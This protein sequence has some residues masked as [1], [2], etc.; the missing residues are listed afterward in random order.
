MRTLSV[1]DGDLDGKIVE[2][3]EALRQRV[4]QAIRFRFQTWFADTRRG[5]PYD[6]II[7]HVATADLA[8]SAV[9]GAIREEGAEEITGVRETSVTVDHDN[10]V[11][12]YHATVTTVYGDMTLN[13][14]LPA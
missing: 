4:V 11:L 6:Q 9:T 14:E 13:E 8:A 1:T 2:G 5:L 7:G 3:L 12:M 10:R